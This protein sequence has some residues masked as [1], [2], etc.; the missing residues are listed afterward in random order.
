MPIYVL[1]ASVITT[2]YIKLYF[3]ISRY[4]RKKIYRNYQIFSEGTVTLKILIK[5]DLV[6]SPYF[7]AKENCPRERA[8]RT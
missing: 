7:I 2:L 1:R 6:Q 5:V 8:C 4:G 3:C